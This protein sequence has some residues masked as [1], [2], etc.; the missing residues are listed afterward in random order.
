MTKDTESENHYKDPKPVN[1]AVTVMVVD[2]TIDR[3][4]STMKVTAIG[5][6]YTETDRE[7]QKA[8]ITNHNDGLKHSTSC[9]TH[10]TKQSVEITEYS[11]NI[12]QG[13]N[14]YQAEENNDVKLSFP[15]QENKQSVEKFPRKSKCQIQSKSSVF[16]CSE[17]CFDQTSQNKVL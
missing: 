13:V 3:P 2:D 17:G 15:H 10:L 5:H 9:R 4:V 1:A 7:K 6:R 16:F 14:S 11:N 12:E 8:D